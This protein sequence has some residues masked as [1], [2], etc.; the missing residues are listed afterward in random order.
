MK[1]WRSAVSSASDVARIETVARSPVSESTLCRGGRGGADRRGRATG[2][3]L[4][5]RRLQNRPKMLPI[6]SY[7]NDASLTGAKFY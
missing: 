4:T 6:V 1:A 5:A 7:L 3:P 2:I